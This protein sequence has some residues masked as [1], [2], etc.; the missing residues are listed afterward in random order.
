MT[1]KT[2]INKLPKKDLHIVPPYLGKLSFQIS[3]RINHIM[4]NILLDSNIRFVFQSKCK[5]SNFFTFK[6]KVPS[7]LHS[8][9]VYKFQCGSCSATYCGKLIVTLMSEC[10]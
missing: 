2:L 1:P 9:I 7:L 6:G 4:E 10:V 8:D 5:I 3:T